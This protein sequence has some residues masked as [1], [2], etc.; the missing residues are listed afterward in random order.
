MG[1]QHDVKAYHSAT[2]APYTYIQPMICTGCEVC[3]EVCPFEAIVMKE[4][5][6]VIL[7]DLC[8]NCKIC[9]RVCP[10]GAIM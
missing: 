9:V 5:T 1:K 8:K 4:G 3:V 6:A 7:K 2:R 10:E